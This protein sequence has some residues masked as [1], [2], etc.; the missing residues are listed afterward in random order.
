MTSPKE[1]QIVTTASQPMEATMIQVALG[2]HDIDSK[3]DGEYTIGVDPLLSNA[4]GGVKVMVAAE[5][6]ALAHQILTELEQNKKE[7]EALK[8]RTCPSCGCEKGESMERPNIIGIASVLT[9]GA[10][11][12]LFPWS[13]YKCPDCGNKWK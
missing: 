12:L 3:L 5:D 7:S 1:W 11:T 2:S 10:F 9:L 8:S 6:L 4:I 13:R